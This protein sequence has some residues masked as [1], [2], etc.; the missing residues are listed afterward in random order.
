MSHHLLT[1]WQR[2]FNLTFNLGLNEQ[3]RDQID[4]LTAVR[5]VTPTHSEEEER[6]SVQGL[7]GD[8]EEENLLSVTKVDVEPEETKVEEIV[9]KLPATSAER[10]KETISELIDEEEKIAMDFEYVPLKLIY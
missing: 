4:V 1:A 8:A 5:P 9:G 6:S 7:V 10:A 2:A 3:F